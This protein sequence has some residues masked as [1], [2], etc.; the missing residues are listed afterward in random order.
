MGGEGWKDTVELVVLWEK[1]KKR[2]KQLL[3]YE[4]TR[5]T[6]VPKI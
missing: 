3:I 2:T 4:H 5:T 6:F 1:D